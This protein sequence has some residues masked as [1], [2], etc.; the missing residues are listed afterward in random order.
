MTASG[1]EAVLAAYNVSRET[2]ARLDILVNEL[3]RWQKIKNLVGPGTLPE[4]W[5]RHIADSLQL[6]AVEPEAR[7]W[8][9]LGSGAGFPGLVIAAALAERDRAEVYLV[10]SNGRKC[11][12]LRHAA[13]LMTAPAHVHET[14]IEAVVAGFSVEKIEVVTA[15]ALAPLSQLVV[16]TEPLLKSGAVGLFPKGREVQ[17]EL[18]E[19]AQSWRLDA[20]LIPSRTDPSGR[21]VRIGPLRE[22][23]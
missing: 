7:R 18:T 12:F 2:S 21:I 11:A 13:R 23:V 4:V 19:A 5:I 22:P 14:R 10:E 8:L 16:W 9:D 3:A 20:E 15:R 17:S 1:R 6:L